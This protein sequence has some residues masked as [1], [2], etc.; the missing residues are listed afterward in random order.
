M[1]SIAQPELLLAML[2][3][4]G[5]YNWAAASAAQ[6]EIW[7]VPACYHIYSFQLYSVDLNYCEAWPWFLVKAIYSLPVCSSIYSGNLQ[8][9]VRL[10]VQH[11][12][13]DAEST[14][15]MIS[16]LIQLFDLDIPM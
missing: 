1:C 6:S 16:S 15:C 2:V 3:H 4:R 11:M 7:A 10:L 9:R 8:V 12:Q 14:G 5:S 13:F